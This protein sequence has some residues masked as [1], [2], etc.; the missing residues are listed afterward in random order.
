[1]IRFRPLALAIHIAISEM[2]MLDAA[3]DPD[4]IE[5]EPEPATAE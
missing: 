2:R 4:A 3:Q 1:M 5:P